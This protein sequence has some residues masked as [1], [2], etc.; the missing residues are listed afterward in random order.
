[1][2]LAIWAIMSFAGFGVCGLPAQGI[3]MPGLAALPVLS[4]VFA[5]E[6]FVVPFLFFVAVVG[7]AVG[8]AALAVGVPS[9]DV[10][11]TLSVVGAAL[12][13]RSMVVFGA[14]GL[15]FGHFFLFGKAMLFHIVRFGCICDFYAWG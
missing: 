10:V 12:G 6:G 11:G 1:M 8:F 2:V 7:A 15:V 9:A 3:C 13:G 5:A 4:D 14:G